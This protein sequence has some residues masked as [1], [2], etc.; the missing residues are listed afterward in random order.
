MADC[1]IALVPILWFV[2]AL[3]FLKVSGMNSCIVAY[4]LSAAAGLLWFGLSVSNIATATV[5]GII[6]GI[7]PILTVIF[8]ALFTFILTEQTGELENIKK[9]LLHITDDKL[10]LLLIIGFGFGNFLEGVAGFGT[11]VIVPAGILVS[12][13]M[14]PVRIVGSLLIMTT[15]TTA[16]G[17]VGVTTL[18]TSQVTGISAD[19]L[20]SN[21]IVIELLPLFLTPYVMIYI[22]GDSWKSIRKMFV[23][24]TISSLAFTIPAF[25]IAYFVGPEL[26]DVAGSISAMVFTILFVKLFHVEGK[27]DE[28]K[29]NTFTL[30][31]G[32][33]SW[34]PFIIMFILLTVTSRLFPYIHDM[35]V[36]VKSVFTIYDGINPSV[37]TINWLTNS[38]D[39]IMISAVIGGFIQG[40]SIREQIQV[41]FKAIYK[42]WSMIVTIC[43]VMAVAI[44][45]NYSGMIRI[46]AMFMVVVTGSFYPFVSPLIGGLGSFV[47]GSATTSSAL[48]GNLQTATAD[49]LEIS[50]A[51]LAAGNL[52]GGGVGKII[53]PQMISLGASA[54]QQPGLDNRIL[55]A[56][57]K[58]FFILISIGGMFCYFIPVIFKL[59]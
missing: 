32:I 20:S 15:M 2:I 53:S 28:T 8:A 40:M 49:A 43:S 54:V 51:W 7:W 17:S 25:C 38:A 56:T 55:R 13:G 5:E 36:S 45:M 58:W 6:D 26:P 10:V 47:T 59:Y 42:N 21:V 9:M 14:D 50:E 4:I 19:V 31:Q 46:I 39:V 34:S 30:Y 18:V 35:L 44:I 11:S 27:A 1:I 16:F 41:F 23:I 29:K 24:T 48:F 37:I 22:C 57:C 12:I 33:R 52:F 3:G